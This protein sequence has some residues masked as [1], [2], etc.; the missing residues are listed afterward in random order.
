MIIVFWQPSSLPL[1]T[2]P[3]FPP[4]LWASAPH[5]SQSESLAHF[6]ISIC[7]EYPSISF[8]VHIFLMNRHLLLPIIFLILWGRVKCQ[9]SC[10]HAQIFIMVFF[11]ILQLCVYMT[12]YTVSFIRVDKVF[13]C[14]IGNS[15]NWLAHCWPEYIWWMS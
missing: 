11:I 5:L 9:S 2:P 3:T 8:Q 7:L 10:H 14:Y 12:F 6:H 1:Q 15:I 13:H 4:H